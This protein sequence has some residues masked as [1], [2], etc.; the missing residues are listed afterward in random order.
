VPTGTSLAKPDDCD[1]AAEC[2]RLQRARQRVLAA[3]LEHL[4]DAAAAGQRADFVLPLGIAAVIDGAER[5]ELARASELRVAR[6]RDDWFRAD[7][8]GEL[9]AEHRDAARALE[10]HEV[11]GFETAAL[12]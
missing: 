10:Q 4:I 7:R 9:Q 6:A 8:G 12:E 3:D 5:A 2:Q 1:V 11:A